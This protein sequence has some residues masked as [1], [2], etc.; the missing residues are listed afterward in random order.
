MRNDNDHVF[1]L[2]WSVFHLTNTTD[3]YTP[4]FRK[5]VEEFPSWSNVVPMVVEYEEFLLPDLH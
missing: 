1:K 4:Q 5:F 2:S 3:S